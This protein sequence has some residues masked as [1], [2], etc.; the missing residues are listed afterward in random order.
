MSENKKYYLVKIHTNW[1]DEMNIDGY[2]IYKEKEYN[3]WKKGWE[4]LKGEYIEVYVGTNQDLEI[5]F[6]DFYVTEITEEQY[7]VFKKLDML[8]FGHTNIFDSNEDVNEE[9]D[10]VEG[11]EWS[12]H[13]SEPND[14]KYNFINS[15]V[16]TY[17]LG[18]YPSWEIPEEFKDKIEYKG[19]RYAILYLEEEID[20][21]K[22]DRFLNINVDS[23]KIWNESKKSWEYH[24]RL[25]STQPPFNI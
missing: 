19:R 2:I 1:A 7:K 25:R 4:K 21:Y 6:D 23:N 10:N 12:C 5:S 24:L 18:Y 17:M 11:E 15:S 22:D 13:N 9:E 8:N 16:N 20:T 3:H 14:I